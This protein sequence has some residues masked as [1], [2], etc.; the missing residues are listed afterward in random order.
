MLQAFTAFV[1]VNHEYLMI[2][3]EGFRTRSSTFFVV[4]RSE[5][6]VFLEREFARVDNE[7]WWAWFEKFG[8][9]ST[10]SVLQPARPS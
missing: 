2:W 9:L 3:C 8:G 6:S 10:L 1:D 4:G 7:S 5:R